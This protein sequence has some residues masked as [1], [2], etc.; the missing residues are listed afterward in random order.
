VFGTDGTQ[1]ARDLQKGAVINAYVSQ[2]TRTITLENIDDAF[3][4]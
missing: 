1:F 2:L 4:I 3:D